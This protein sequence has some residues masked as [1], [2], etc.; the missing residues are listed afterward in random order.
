MSKKIDWEQEAARVYS[1]IGKGKANAIS[2]TD[3][4]MLYGGKDRDMRKA[5]SYARLTGKAINNDQDRQG[6]YIPDTLEELLRQYKQTEDRGKAILAQLK[7][8]RAEI[9]KI[10]NADQ[11]ALPG[12]EGELEGAF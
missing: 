6:Y 7:A 9:E 3:L 11:L 12:I 8:I 5:I 4:L 10:R 1:L 2:R